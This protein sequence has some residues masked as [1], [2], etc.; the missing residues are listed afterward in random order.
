MIMNYQ[1]FANFPDHRVTERC[2]YSISDLLT[3][4]LLAYRCGEEGG[5]DMSEFVHLRTREFGR[6][7]DTDRVPYSDAFER[8][9]ASVSPDELDRCS[10]E[11]G[12]AFLSSLS[13]K[14]VSINGKT[15]RLRPR[16]ETAGS[17][18]TM[19]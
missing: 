17:R 10:T 12:R 11:H 5:V 4:A 8:L 18:S 16:M 6:L 9:M 13:E 2:L 19:Q 15:P 3:I 7:V 1:I 14:L